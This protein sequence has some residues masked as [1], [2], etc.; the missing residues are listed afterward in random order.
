MGL[1]RKTYDGLSFGDILKRIIRRK[2]KKG[3]ARIKLK[4]IRVKLDLIVKGK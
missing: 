3:I 2:I 1:K 4:T